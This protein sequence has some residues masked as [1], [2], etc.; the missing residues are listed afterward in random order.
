MKT[1][2]T[3]LMLM[4]TVLA[5]GCADNLQ[6]P[7]TNVTPVAVA[8][9]MDD[10]RGDPV[11][12]FSGKPVTVRLDGSQSR[13]PDGEIRKYRWLS[14]TSPNMVGVT[15]DAM[16]GL[17]AGSVAHDRW[18]PEGAAKDWPEDVMQPEVTLPNV[19]NYA[20]TLWVTDDR[21]RISDPSTISV[22]VQ[23]AE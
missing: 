23:P 18:V 5:F 17:D 16:S 11:V 21:G 9:V 3:P 6:V 22:R 4:C 7:L 15:D 14:A 12:T 19:G 13:D 1:H 2:I 10:S 20:F 8:R